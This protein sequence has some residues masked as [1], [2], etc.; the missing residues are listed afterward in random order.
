MSSMLPIDGEHD[1]QRGRKVG[2]NLEQVGSLMQRLLHQL[3]LLV[4]K[5]LDGLLQITH[6]AVDEFGAATAGP[7][8]KVVL[9]YEGCVES[10]GGDEG[11]W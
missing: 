11:E 2:S 6:A 5:L 9:L 10:F 7:G 4:V 3:V 8:G 1:G